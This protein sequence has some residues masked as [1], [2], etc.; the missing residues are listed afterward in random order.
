MLFEDLHLLENHKMTNCCPHQN[1][2][3]CKLHNKALK[4]NHLTL[5]HGEIWFFI[6]DLAINSFLAINE[7]ICLWS[8]IRLIVSLRLNHLAS[9]CSLFAVVPQLWRHADY[10]RSLGFEICISRSSR[11]SAQ[12]YCCSCERDARW[13][14]S[15]W[16]SDI[17]MIRA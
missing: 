6:Y 10:F 7:T 11:L 14:D 4:W 9:L 8:K 16:E 15:L 2:S 12:C 17:R 1:L 13:T 5:L 3:N